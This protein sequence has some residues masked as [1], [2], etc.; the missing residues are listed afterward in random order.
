MED[1]MSN[2]LKVIGDQ[3]TA[4][5]HAKLVDK[6]LIDDQGMTLEDFINSAEPIL[7]NIAYD[8]A[9]AVKWCNMYLCIEADGLCHS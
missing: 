1:T 6:W 7:P 2:K 8:G 5:Q 4:E 9:I 3:I